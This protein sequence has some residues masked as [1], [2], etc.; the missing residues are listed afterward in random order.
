VAALPKVVHELFA[1][2]PAAADDDDLDFVIHIFSF[3][4]FLLI[5]NQRGSVSRL[6][7]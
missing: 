2:E 7:A 5:A 1:D 3:V 4:C 6:Q